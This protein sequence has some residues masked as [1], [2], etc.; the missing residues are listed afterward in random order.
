MLRG[1]MTCL[2]VIALSAGAMAE[3]ETSTVGSLWTTLK[4]SPSSFTYSMIVDSARDDLEQVRGLDIFHDF[5][6]SWKLTDKDDV[7]IA[8]EWIT[9]Y[10]PDDYFASSPRWNNRYEGTEFRYRRKSLLTEEEHGVDLTLQVRY[11]YNNA[12]DNHNGVWSNRAYFNQ[13]LT[14]SIGLLNY[15]R[16]DYYDENKNKV[17][18]NSTGADRQMRFRYYFWPSISLRDDLTLG[19]MTRYEYVWVD[20]QVNA[21]TAKKT[22]RVQFIP[23]LTW[24]ATPYDT[25]ELYVYTTFMQGD[26]GETIRKA[27]DIRHDILYEFI[28]AWTIF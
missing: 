14:D 7:R 26:D 3:E 12:R 5:L 13:Q 22:N 24:N 10:R 27:E 19:L 17:I 23:S 1:L 9:A 6:V 28:W 4:D 18:N 21:D 8:P 25:F 16:L 15:L 20:D 11:F 2:V